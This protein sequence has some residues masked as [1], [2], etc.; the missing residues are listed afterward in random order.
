MARFSEQGKNG[1]TVNVEWENVGDFN[2]F[3]LGMLQGG[4]S[5]EFNR[6]LGIATLNA[7]RTFLKP[8]KAEAPVWGGA[9]SQASAASRTRNPKRTG[10]TLRKGIVA[11]RGKLDRPSALIGISLGGRGRTGA[12]YRNMVVSG[13]VDRGATTGGKGGVIA[14]WSAF[15]SPTGPYPV[16]PIRP[17]ANGGGG[18]TPGNDFLRRV[19][20]RANLRAAA[21][22]TLNKTILA[23]LNGKLGRLQ[24][25]TRWQ[26]KGR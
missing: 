3:R 25:N 8:A 17:K 10:G 24:T 15:S 5:R 1:L 19:T 22:D 26:R 13:H 18:R 4:N 12:W 21:V 7:A 20:D 6:L 11:R 23:Y 14:P 9:N 16:A 2:A